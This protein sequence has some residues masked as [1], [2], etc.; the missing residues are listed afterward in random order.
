MRF[1]KDFPEAQNEVSRDLAELGMLVQPETM[2]AIYVADNPE[3]Q[4]KELANY[5]YTVTRP[6]YTEIEGVHEDWIHREWRDRLA[7]GLNPGTAWKQREEIWRPLLEAD[8][9]KGNIARFSYTYSQ[10][11]GGEHI[12]AIIDEIKLHPHSRQL[13]LPVWDRN[14]DEKRRGKKRV[15]CSLGYQFMMRN[16]AIHITYMMRSCDLFTHFPND[17]AMANIMQSFVAEQTGYEVGSF[18]HFIGSLHAYRKD[19]ASIF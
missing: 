17:I 4:T 13:F 6:D 11:M 10:R 18:T 16:D 9:P 14:I 7:G 19:L 2:Q 12:I 15:P 5:I 8:D 1:F 3:F